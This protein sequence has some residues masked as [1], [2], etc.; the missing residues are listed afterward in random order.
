MPLIEELD[1]E[2]ETLDSLDGLVVKPQ[3]AEKLAES[4][5]AIRMAC[6]AASRAGRGLGSLEEAIHS[7][8]CRGRRCAV[9][10]PARLSVVARSRGRR[11]LPPQGGTASAAAAPAPRERPSAPAQP[12]SRP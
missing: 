7:G 1:V 3:V 11:R 6:A 2:V 12:P 10:A 4:A 8:A 5:P 9:A